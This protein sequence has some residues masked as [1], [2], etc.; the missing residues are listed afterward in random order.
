VGRSRARGSLSAYYSPAMD[1]ARPPRRRRR[2][3]RGTVERPVNTR[4]V[5]VAAVVVAPA[6]LA[7]LFSISTTGQLPRPTLQ[8]LFDRTAAAALASQLTTVDPSRVPG[9]LQDAEAANWY[10]ETI[11]AYGFSTSEDVWE[12]DLPDLGRVQLRNVVTVIPGRSPQAIVVVAHR[13]NTGAGQRF[14][15]NASG[16]AALI[17]IARGFAPQQTAPAPMPQRTLVLLSTDGGAYGG[18]GAARF[19]SVSPYAKDAIAAIVLDGVAG[20]GRPRIDLAGD[21]PHSPAP[22]LVSTAV[23][24]V[25]E[26][27]GDAPALPS[28]PA[29]LASQALP[30][31][32][33]EQGRLLRKGIASLTLTTQE[34]GDPA[35]P[36]G[37]PSG[38]ISVERLGQLGRATE[39]LVGS[40]DANVGSPLR[41]P[42]SLFFHGRVA[43]GWA[44]RL[45][46]IL[47]VVPFALG[48]F[49]LLVRSRRRRLPLRPALRALRSR[50]LFW[51]Y[52]GILLWFG[53]MLGVFP[54][55]P[56]LPPP[57]Y[58]HEITNL[59]LAGLV[60]LG[61]ALVAGWILGRRRLV[62]TTPA[63]GE[64]RLAGY[65][66]A[67]TWLAFVALGVALANPY[68]LLFVIPSLY[69]W[70]A[71]PLQN[72]IWARAALFATGLLG[73]LL[74][75]LVLS[76]ELGLSLPRGAF[77]AVGL[78]T[79]GYLPLRTVVLTLAWLA[80]AAQIAAL[81][82]GRYAP[83]AGGND[84]PTPGPVRQLVE[85]RRRPRPY[86]SVK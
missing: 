6:L 16:T 48:T 35:V 24:R 13:D 66:V 71:L 55:S 23:A 27:T 56:A 65:A 40:L 37:D 14:G 81:A 12:Q 53:T 58:A 17:E 77:Y 21:R 68:A 28:L 80:G 86:A 8:P 33:G 10:R 25:R 52:A 54:D 39:A 44:A 49:D 32:A 3:R 62:A 45:T 78:A 74:I 7:F 57:P 60:L 50:I 59:P 41:T 34:R 70:L 42:D 15:D 36:V 82:F 5:R 31:A 51:L 64:E 18:A 83:Y 72:A 84:P 30:F 4:L 11:G 38:R 61:A 46:L 20:G 1:A 75:L 79:T 85:R 26:Q 63:S 43:S 67:L 19:A 73:P 2:P 29:Q 22:A 76:G 9:S 69:A 47:A